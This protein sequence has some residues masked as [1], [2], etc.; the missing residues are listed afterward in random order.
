MGDW[1]YFRLMVQNAGTLMKAAMGDR[2]GLDKLLDE[3]FYEY[4]DRKD[5]LETQNIEDRSHECNESIR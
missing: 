4:N 5:Y 1:L 2:S 3:M